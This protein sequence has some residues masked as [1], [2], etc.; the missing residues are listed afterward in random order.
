MACG[1]SRNRFS[2]GERTELRAKSNRQPRGLKARAFLLVSIR[3]NRLVDVCWSTG[4]CPL[5]Q[6]RLHVCA[7]VI[8]SIFV[9]KA[10]FY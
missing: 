7:S 2:V 6:T 9:L 3:C 5:G 4:Q 1:F 8:A 10:S